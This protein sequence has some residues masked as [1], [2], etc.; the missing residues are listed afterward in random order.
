MARDPELAVTGCC[1]RWSGAGGGFETACAP[2][3]GSSA[4]WVAGPESSSEARS[5]VIRYR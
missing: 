1:T 5:S 2:I 3:E 4:A